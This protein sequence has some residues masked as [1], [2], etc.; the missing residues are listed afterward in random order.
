MT[1]KQLPLF[2]S[3]SNIEPQSKKSALIQK[4][5]AIDI[6]KDQSGG[7]LTGRTP[8]NALLAL[9]RGY[10]IKGVYISR[11][12]SLAKERQDQKTPLTRDD[13]AEVIGITWAN[14]QGMANVMRRLELLRAKNTLKPFGELV[15]E[16]NPYLDNK[17]LLWFMHYL[18]ASNA[19]LVL[20]S[21]AFNQLF[22]DV[23][24]LSVQDAKANFTILSGRWSDKTIKEKIPQEIGAIF[25][26]YTEGLFSPLRLLKK[27]ETGIFEVNSNTD[28]IH[29]SIW[30]ACILIY[31]DRYY[32][33]APSLEVP[34]VV[35]AHYS[36]GRLFR[37]SEL[38]TRRA[39]DELHNAGLLTVETRSGLDQVRF[40]RNTTWLSV[41]ADFLVGG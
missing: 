37:Q 36:P 26:S 22:I 1:H 41:V 6:N 39:L 27:F 11:I 28:L 24:T 29:P 16:N 9:N 17:G 33:G 13:I 8:E 32:P 35:D 21:H 3:Q 12:L 18:L 31:R 25:R 5:D 10:V 2:Q 20:W 7:G 19:L 15:L 34:L 40:K 30:L 23:E 38:A 4:I 14:T